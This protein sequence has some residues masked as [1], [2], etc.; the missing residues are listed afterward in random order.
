[1]GAELGKANLNSPCRCTHPG[2]PVT[3]P[4]LETVEVPAYRPFRVRVTR[5]QRLSP[6]FVRITFGGSDLDEF[7]SN[8]FDQ[9]I[10]VVVPLPGRGTVECPQ[11]PDWYGAW[12]ALPPKQRNPLR[13]YTVRAARPLERE[14]DVDFVLHGPSG[15]A[16]AWAGQARPGDDLVLV[17]PDARCPR[18]TGGFEWHPPAAASELLLAGDETAVPAICAIAEALPAGRPVRALLEV[19]TVADVLDVRT[20]PG[21]E[22]TWLPR[23]SSGTGRPL[24]E[25]LTEAVLRAVTRSVT[26]TP[27]PAPD[28][29]DADT[30]LWEVPED[31]GSSTGGGIYAWLAGEA[32]VVT[33]LR[34][35]LLSEV[36]V[37]RRRV[38]F[39]G[40][41]RQGRSLD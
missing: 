40:Y 27:G 14:V 32:G 19:P 22:V 3:V 13:S 35:R 16:G 6:A 33:A 21:I 17:G 11:G 28:R 38:A 26:A 39:M 9:R 4:A 31:E 12:R 29:V 24:G 7:A 36:G 10:K 18:P 37:D 5:V 30:L 1:M 23:R 2:D 34:R 8:G 20:A 41:W 25:P 15:P